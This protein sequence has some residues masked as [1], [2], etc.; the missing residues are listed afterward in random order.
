MKKENKRKIMHLIFWTI[1]IAAIAVIVFS[2]T[3]TDYKNWEWN[4]EWECVENE[5]IN[6]T[7]CLICQQDQATNQTICMLDDAKEE[8]KPECITQAKIRRRE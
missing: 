5:P 8:C 6:A 7:N 2:A 4:E 1:I 3:Y